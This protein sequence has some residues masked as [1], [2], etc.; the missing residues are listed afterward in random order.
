MTVVCAE[1]ADTLAVGGRL[2]AEIRPGDIVVLAGGLGA[3]KTLFVGGLAA[4]LGVQEPVTSPSFVLMREYRSGFIPVIHVDVYRLGSFNEFE[5]LDIYERAL[6]GVLAVEWGDVVAG[7][8]PED[9]LV[10]RFEVDSDGVRTLA[11]EPHGTWAGRDL[12][13]VIR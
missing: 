8:L 9:H 11:F 3:G 10:V 13:R 4:G 2:A 1:E 12:S 7:A 6:D 5:D